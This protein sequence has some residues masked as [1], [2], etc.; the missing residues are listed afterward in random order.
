[1]VFYLFLLFAIMPIIEISVLIQ[2]GTALGAP[3][4][5]ALVLITA[6]VGAS[7]VRSQ[8]LSTLM[9]V[10]NRMNRGELP[11]TQIMEAM[12]LAVAGVLLVTPGFVTDFLGLLVLT[13]LTRKRLATWLLSRVQVRTVHS[14]GFGAEFHQQQGPFQQSDPFQRPQQPKDLDGKSTIEG[15]Y[16]RKD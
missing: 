8:G 16:E 10:R 15:E 1:M 14:Q 9:E 4:T 3:T 11:G 13:P 12:L 5:I 7:L 6:A 2:V